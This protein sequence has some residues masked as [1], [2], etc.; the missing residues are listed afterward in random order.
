MAR[1]GEGYPLGNGHMGAMVLGSL[2][3]TRIDL[4]ENTFYSGERSSHTN[5]Q[6][7]A[8]TAFYAM[9][10]QAET[11]NYDKVHEIAENFI[12][13]RK[14][15]GTNLP[16]GSLNVDYGI[17][18]EE[19]SNYERSLSLDKGIVECTFLDGSNP[20]KEDI[21][22][23]HPD[24]IMVYHL[25]SK[26]KL[27]C[28]LSFLP[29]NEFGKVHYGTEH[30][31]FTCHAYET[32]HCDELKG[33]T[34]TGYGQILTDGSSIALDDGIKIQNASDIRILLYM[35]TNFKRESIEFFQLMQETKEHVFHCLQKD[36]EEVK[37]E[38]IK[39]INSYMS[40]VDF[41]LISADSWSDKVP[42]LY[43]YGRY[44]LLSSS[45][46]DSKLPAHLQGIWNDNVACRIGW[47]CDM[48]LDINTQMNYWPSEAANLQNTAKPLFHW[49]K[50]DLAT[51]GEITAKEAYGLKGW[52][53]ELVS[54]AW[55]FA[56]PYWASPIAPCPTG[57]IWTLMQLWEHYL[58]TEDENFLQNTAFP[59]IESAAAFFNDYV[60]IDKQTGYFTCG[61][62]ISPENSF[63]Y[64]E[65]NYQ[66]SNGCTYEILMIREIFDVYLKG[67]LILKKDNS[68]LFQDISS[69]IKRLLPYR[70]LKDGTIAEWN[71]D[72]ESADPQHRHTSH[73]LG[74]FPF[75]Q[76]N[77]DE[78][79]NLCT[80]VKK[81]IE[82]KLSP[83]ENWEDT[84]WARSMLLLYAAR[85]REGKS[86]YE[87]LKSMMTNLLEPNNLVYHPPTRG[88]YAFDHVYEL[89]GNT[90]FTTGVSEMLLQS[91]REILH[92]LPALPEE[93]KSGSITGIMARGNIRIDLKWED[94]EL[95]T[96]ELT[97]QKDKKCRV[98]Y[99]NDLQEIQLTGNE[100]FIYKPQI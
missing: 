3:V 57:G 5:N 13:I 89:D 24:N 85:L 41:K 56:A 39:D 59:L 63:L 32:M 54:N 67:S 10:E 76:I 60:F 52:V 69:K 55:G 62:S 58:Y 15:Y 26:G 99:K 49:I 70:I 80:A 46:S 14:N 48:H 84:G 23:S 20:I 66:I 65:R 91:Q 51:A 19:I 44:L 4:S 45:R 87:H 21:F 34:L 50:E 77:P 95:I 28:K 35:N 25:S 97:S 9:R 92:F 12:G 7:D 42:L 79:E 83:L 43:Q 90:G 33:V 27:N 53:G 61:P 36:M 18:P 100:T 98:R 1:W 96:A 29:G 6:K 73:L 16:V 31:Q 30:F 86:A 93:W 64:N 82:K 88:A 22:I 72:L 40:K 47:T 94:G 71:H 38:H 68:K 37:K 75:S 11:G 74:L 17:F 2:P 8:A 81:T 78:T